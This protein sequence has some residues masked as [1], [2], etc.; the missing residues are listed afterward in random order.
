MTTSPTS[1]GEFAYDL[2]VFDWDG[3]LMDTTGLIARGIQHAAR[4][5]GYTPLFQRYSNLD[6]SSFECLLFTLHLVKS[7]KVTKLSKQWQG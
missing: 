2:V 1:A 3:T 4:V 7:S 6:M 5:M